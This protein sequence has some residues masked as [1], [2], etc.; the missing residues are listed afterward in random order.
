MHKAFSWLPL[1]QKILIKKTFILYLFLF[2]CSKVPNHS[3]RQEVADEKIEAF[4]TRFLLQEGGIYTLFGDKPMTDACFFIGA[5]KEI[6]LD[7]LSEEA[8]QRVVYVDHKSLLDNWLAWKEYARSIPLKV[9]CFVEVPCPTDPL[10]VLYYLINTVRVKEVIEE[11]KEEFRTRA[12]I[13]GDNFLQDLQNPK[14]SFWH[15]ILADHY[16]M[17][18]LHGYGKENSDYFIQVLEGVEPAN[19]SE[20]FHFTQGPCTL[21]NFPLP[22]YA[23]LEADP[24]RDKYEEQ[25]E[26]IKKNYKNRNFLRVTLN[27]LRK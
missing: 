5:E 1:L 18:L 19:L 14:S 26:T 11:N 16:L 17:G 25:R 10:H 13:N 22:V 24:V 27:Q 6:S 9:F 12:G 20:K 8:L 23:S 15:N 3:I 21:D 4:L 7:G 2:G